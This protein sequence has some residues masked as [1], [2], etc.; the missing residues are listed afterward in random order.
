MRDEFDETPG[1]NSTGGS[2]KSSISISDGELT[3]EDL[4][5]KLLTMLPMDKITG[6]M[7]VRKGRVSKT[8]DIIENVFY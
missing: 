7:T 1:K 5:V 6:M 4:L 8:I 3:R 2:T